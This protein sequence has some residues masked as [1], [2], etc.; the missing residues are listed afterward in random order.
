MFVVGVV[1]D[2]DAAAVVVDVVVVVVVIQG[3]VA[4]VAYRKVSI[5]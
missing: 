4:V 1:E 5:L 3:I 2:G